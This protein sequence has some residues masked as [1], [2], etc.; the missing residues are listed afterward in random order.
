MELGTDSQSWAEPTG[1][2]LDTS[3][4]PGL[5][6]VQA[7]HLQPALY[8]NSTNSGSQLWL[9]IRIASEALKFLEFPCGSAA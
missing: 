7:R 4:L 8:A 5:A 3:V 9:Q 6:R 2:R 1:L